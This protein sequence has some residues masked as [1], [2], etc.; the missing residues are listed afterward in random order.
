MSLAIVMVVV[1]DYNGTKFTWEILLLSLT[2]QVSAWQNKSNGTWNW[3]SMCEQKLLYT[4]YL[5]VGDKT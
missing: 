2:K 4:F 5:R 3:L 1:V